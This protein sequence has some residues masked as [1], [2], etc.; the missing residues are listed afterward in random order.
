MAERKT[1]VCTQG[2]KPVTIVN[3]KVVCVKPK[4]K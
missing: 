4:G 1:V 2:S 3:R